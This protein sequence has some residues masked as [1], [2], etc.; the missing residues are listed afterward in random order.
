MRVDGGREVRQVIFRR[1]GLESAVLLTLT[2]SATPQKQG[3][4]LQV[5]PYDVVN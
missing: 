4:D 1:K 2:S 5:M 3:S